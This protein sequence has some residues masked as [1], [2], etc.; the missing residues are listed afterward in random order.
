MPGKRSRPRTCMW[1]AV[2]SQG[3]AIESPATAYPAVWARIERLPSKRRSGRLMPAIAQL[4]VKIQVRGSNLVE[5]IVLFHPAA[6]G[7][8]HLRPP[9]RIVPQLEERA[10]RL[11][12]VRDRGEHARV[13]EQPVLP[14]TALEQLAAG[15]DV[16]GHD[17]N[18]ARHGFE[19][20]HRL[21]FAQAGEHR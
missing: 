8:S 6:A 1:S 2:R 7:P 9:H 20:D 10:R 18:P 16:R 11:L 17:R 14:G 15:A 21:A 5:P 3:P 13:A 19:D 12:R 4:S